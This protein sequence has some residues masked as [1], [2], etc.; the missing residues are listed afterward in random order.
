MSKRRLQPA[1]RPADR[2]VSSR[3]PIEREVRYKVLGRKKSVMCMGSGK[4]LN[5]SSSG[6]L[7]TTEST[8]PEG[9]SV[10]IAISWPVQLD[11]ATH[12]KLVVLG[13]LVRSDEGR[14]V[15]SIERYEFKTRG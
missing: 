11:K 7:F 9:A 3:L 6:I 8:L 5:M 15:I 14:A 12:L 4:T 1:G 2:R 13:D 10:E